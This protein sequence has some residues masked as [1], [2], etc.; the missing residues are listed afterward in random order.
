MISWKLFC[1]NKSYT[2]FYWLISGQ[3]WGIVFS[4]GAQVEFPIW[5]IVNFAQI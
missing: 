4:V 3:R 2:N 1:Y 5:G